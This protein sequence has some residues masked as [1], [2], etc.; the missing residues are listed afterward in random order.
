MGLP[1]PSKGFHGSFM[2]KVVS[3][4]IKTSPLKVP[5]KAGTSQ[6]RRRL[7]V[8]ELG[9]D[10]SASFHIKSNDIYNFKNKILLIKSVRS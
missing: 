7:R 2:N 4:N 8:G 5:T 1:S 10:V 6:A 3:P 9:N